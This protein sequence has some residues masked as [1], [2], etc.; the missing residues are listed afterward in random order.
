MGVGF[1]LSEQDIIV[2]ELEQDDKFTKRARPSVIYFGLIIIFINHVVA[3]FVTLF[4]REEM[5]SIYLP[6]QFWWAWG[7]VL[8]VYI[9]GRSGEK[10][11]M[12]NKF[13]SM[14]SG[15]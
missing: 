9:L 6:E 15:K 10:M 14:A 1:N 4:A 2:A 5:V 3:P 12:K 7:S 13:T 11:G 8:S